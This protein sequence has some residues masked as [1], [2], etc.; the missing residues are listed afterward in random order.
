MVAWSA[1]TASDRRSGRIWS[2]Q[3][4]DGLHPRSDEFTVNAFKESGE[5][6]RRKRSPSSLSG[7][8]AQPEFALRYGFDS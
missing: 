5:G 3:D 2:G 7:T 8:G 1:G 6:C 4:R